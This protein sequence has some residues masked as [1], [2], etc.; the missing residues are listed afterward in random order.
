MKNCEKIIYLLWSPQEQSGEQRHKILLKECAGEI[1]NAGAEKLVIYIHDA[2]SDIKSPAPFKRSE[3]PVTAEVEVCLKDVSLSKLIEAILKDKGFKLAGYRVDES[4]YREYGGNMHMH[5]RDWADG[6]RSPGLVSVNLLKR[7][8]KLPVEEWVRRWHNIMSPVSEAIQPRTRYVRNFVLECITPDA[9]PYNGIV[10]EAWPS[11]RHVANKMLFFGADT[12]FQL[13]GNMLKI[14]RA[15]K[16]F[17][18]IKDI[19]TVMMSEYF[20]KTDF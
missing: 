12:I 20:M 4:I 18:K 9:P 7:P 17:L 11:K 14:L 3:E 1:I 16:S 6:R 19:R 5:Q 13:I 8:E 2:D 10:I 15:V